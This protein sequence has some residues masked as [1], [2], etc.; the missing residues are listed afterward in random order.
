MDSV[1]LTPL[2]QIHHP[3]GNIY[4]ALKKGDIGY[5]GFG[6]AYFSTIRHNTIKGWK[7]H[8]KMV[9]NLVV[10][11]GGIEI[12]IY[13][14][15]EFKSVLL[16]PENYKRLT[17]KPNLWVAFKGLGK[18]LNLM[19]NLANIEHDSSESVDIDLNEI[20]YHWT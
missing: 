3:K 15:K 11:V 16:S 10:P 4:T 12:V 5:Y 17:I 13:D 8:T 7:K 20:E 2:K 18:G 6:E 14:E 19:L 9:L 1:I